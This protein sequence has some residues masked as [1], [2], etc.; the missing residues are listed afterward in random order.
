[1]TTMTHIPNIWL[2]LV[3]GIFQSRGRVQL[4]DHT[5][6]VLMVVGASAVTTRIAERGER[7]PSM[8]CHWKRDVLK[9]KRWQEGGPVCLV[10]SES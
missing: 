7:E 1:M 6:G 9:M 4:C 3:V 8:E 10:L 2:K 5:A